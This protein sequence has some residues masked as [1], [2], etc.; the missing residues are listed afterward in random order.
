MLLAQVLVKK[1]RL[2]HKCQDANKSKNQ[3]KLDRKVLQRSCYSFIIN[4]ILIVLSV[5]SLKLELSLYF[6]LFFEN[7]WARFGI[8][9]KSFCLPLWC[10]FCELPS[11]IHL[12]GIAEYFCL[13]FC[14]VMSS[15]VQS[16]QACNNYSTYYRYLLFF[17]PTFALESHCKI[18][19]FS[20]SSL[21]TVFRFF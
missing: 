10:L 8:A 21:A 19:N 7:W 12:F 16:S 13:A 3:K 1:R 6:I 15:F 18:V 5:K 9:F 17:Q 14:K 4:T 20:N 2:L 11:V